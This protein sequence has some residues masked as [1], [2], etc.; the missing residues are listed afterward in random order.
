MSPHA[1]ISLSLAE[2]PASN[3]V[4]TLPQLLSVFLMVGG[5]LTL[6]WAFRGRLG[7]GRAGAR[8][9]A[10]QGPAAGRGARLEESVA[11]A[12]ELAG[13]LE[14]QV[15]GA[16]RRLERLIEQADEKIRR[17]ERLAAAETPSRG[18]R[19]EAPAVDPLNQQVYTLADDGL[20]P[21]EIARQLQQHTGK[22][23]LILALRKR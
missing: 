7:A 6:I 4:V 9:P 22:V 14:G 13:L 15:D 2:L 21:V 20:P 8:G 16:A 1:S 10:A 18:Y 19:A 11:Q 23:E 17:L 5:I 3:L 12:R